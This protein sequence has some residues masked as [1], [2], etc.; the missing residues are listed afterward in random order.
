M[1]S[2]KKFLIDRIELIDIVNSSSVS[3]FDPAI[4]E[5]NLNQYVNLQIKK[6]LCDRH[7]KAKESLAESKV[8]G[9]QAVQ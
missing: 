8:V 6:L 5:L 1:E 4:R 3:R 7:K 9:F 2:Y